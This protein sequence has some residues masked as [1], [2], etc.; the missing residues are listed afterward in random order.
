M[1]IH[2]QVQK[3]KYK[4]QERSKRGERE[5]NDRRWGNREEI[6]PETAEAQRPSS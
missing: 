1:E 6:Q 2:I 4:H 5:S 3:F